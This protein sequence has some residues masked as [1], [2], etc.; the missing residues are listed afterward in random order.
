M[1]S[2][3][4]CRLSAWGS[5]VCSKRSTVVIRTRIGSA[6]RWQSS[7]MPLNV[8]GGRATRGTAQKSCSFTT[9]A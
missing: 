4:P 9:S 3:I 8:Q 7:S 2:P 5:T 1:L 6:R